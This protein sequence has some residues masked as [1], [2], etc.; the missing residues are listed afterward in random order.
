MATVLRTRFKHLREQRGL[1]LRDLA[2]AAVVP[3][4]TLSALESG[5]RSVDGVRVI[6]AKRLARALGVDLNYLGGMY[7]EAE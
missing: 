2:R 5:T 4:S 3:V 6:T 7:E 1:S